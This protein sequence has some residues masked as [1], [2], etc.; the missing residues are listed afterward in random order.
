M[1][2]P[3]SLNEPQLR[4]VLSNARIVVSPQ[5]RGTGKTTDGSF[6]TQRV[7]HEM[8]LA[9]GALVQR[10][11]K[12][13][14]EMTLPPLIAGWEALGYKENK[15]FWVR[16]RPP[17]H[18]DIPKPIQGPTTFEHAICWYTGFVFYLVSQDRPND[19]RG[20]SVQS[21]YLDESV[22]LHLERLQEEVFP[23]L[24]G[25][26]EIYKRSSLYRSI[27][28]TSSKPIG[29]QGRW[30]L[31]FGKYYEKDG[32]NHERI[33]KELTEIELEIIR[34]ETKDDRVKWF[35]ERQKRKKDIIYY[36][37][38]NG[39]FYSEA[40]IF[41]NI[42][43]I[44]FSYILD[45]YNV[46]YKVSPI[47]FLVEILNVTLDEVEGCFYPALDDK[48]HVYYDAID[49]SRIDTLG[50][51]I[52]NI[53]KIDSRDCLDCNPNKPLI[54]GCDW[55]TTTFICIAQ[56]SGGYL[57]FIKNIYALH[58]EYL[59]HAFEKFIDF[60]RHHKRKTI[61]FH[62][63]HTGN[64]RMGNSKLTMA[65]QA[66]K[67]LRRHG[68]KVIRGRNRSAP[69]PEEKYYLWQKVLS[70]SDPNLP[71]VR[72][73]GDNCKELIKSMQFSPVKQ[74]SKSIQKDKSS[75][76][77][78]NFPQEE[79]THGS[80]AADILLT[81]ECTIRRKTRTTDMRTS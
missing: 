35:K 8:P 38:D 58:P 60:F 4:N 30:L 26:K 59:D 67:I 33:Y 6:F 77:D 69:D 56:K 25:L 68:W 39:V 72:I 11:Y 37:N 16:K 24:R 12:L 31:D 48:K 51:D 27:K 36:V 45:L 46:I 65:Q 66:E 21:L 75:E 52:K 28:F 13:L 57:N 14:L 23:A 22:Y 10:S 34:S 63:D 43:N 41:D 32:H 5:G 15:H 19:F 29:S 7:V 55:G 53:E 61:Y 17:A 78:S 70:E 62:Y 44:G 74:G 20:P 76:R 50:L 18:L 64:S 71:I 1:I 79:S 40:N 80:D 2:K 9:T 73:N 81:G 47:K 54:I 42:Q 3:L 49:Y